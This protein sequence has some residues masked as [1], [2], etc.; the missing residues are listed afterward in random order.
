MTGCEAGCD[1]PL[2]GLS[3][4]RQSDGERSWFA[5]KLMITGSEDQS[6]NTRIKDRYHYPVIADTGPWESVL[7]FLPLK[8]DDKCPF[9]AIDCPR[10]ERFGKLLKVLV[11]FRGTQW[12]GCNLNS[13]DR[14]GKWE[15]A[16]SDSSLTASPHLIL[17]PRWVNPAK[18]SLEIPRDLDQMIKHQFLKY[19]Q[20]DRKFI[21]FLFKYV[22]ITQMSALLKG[23][24]SEKEIK[25]ITWSYFVQSLVQLSREY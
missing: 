25:N 20:N 5:V 24:A 8:L 14:D 19:F 16:P 11:F 21:V 10:R 9:G 7:F 13:T 17:C 2:S 4:P 22:C 3:V 12:E 23:I 15:T 1:S 18:T 6:D